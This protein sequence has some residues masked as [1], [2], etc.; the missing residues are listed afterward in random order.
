MPSRCSVDGRLPP[1][2]SLKPTR[3]LV[4][5]LGSSPVALCTMGRGLNQDEASFVAAAAAGR[6][7]ATQLDP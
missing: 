3:G 2:G 5:A 6:F 1:Y 4:E 7:A